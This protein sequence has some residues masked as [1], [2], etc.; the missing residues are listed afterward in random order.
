MRPAVVSSKKHD[1]DLGAREA[2]ILVKVSEFAQSLFDYDSAASHAD[3]RLRDIAWRRE[4]GVLALGTAASLAQ[5][6][7]SRT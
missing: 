1:R 7:F 4:N 2:T 6:I 3:P 5:S